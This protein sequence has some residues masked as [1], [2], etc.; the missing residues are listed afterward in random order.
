[1]IYLHSLGTNQYECIHLV[2]FLC[3]S[4][5]ALF[6]FDFPGCGISDGNMIPLDGSGVYDVYEA[7][8]F[9]DREF[10]FDKYSIWGRSMGAS[11]ALHSVSMTKKFC[12]IISDSSFKN[13]RAIVEEQAKMNGFPRLFIYL[14]EPIIKREAY[15]ILGSE[16]D[17]PQPLSEVPFSQTPLLMGHGK[18]DTFVSASQ[19][20]EL[21]EQYGC[22]DKQLYIFDARHNSSRPA[23]WYETASR[24]LFRKMELPS[25]Q[26]SYASIYNYSQIHIGKKDQIIQE[27]GNPP[28]E[29]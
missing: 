2:P 27:I 1:L 11:I 10:G 16:I 24:F 15:N 22:S 17:N 3:N 28:K 13:T 8:S 4:D 5:L 23:Q 29:T 26:R 7:V 9:L 19:A 18:N 21:Y 6:S 25:Q 20:Y 14:L 12:C